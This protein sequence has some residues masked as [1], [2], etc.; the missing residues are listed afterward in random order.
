VRDPSRILLPACL[1]AAAVG[2][3]GSLAAHSGQH[4][5]GPAAP[6]GARYTIASLSPAVRARSFRFAGVA[7]LDQQA[8][9]TA[10]AAARPEA[11]RLIDLV[12]GL[13]T[14]HVGPTGPIGTTAGA[15][16]ETAAHPDGTYDVTL[17]FASV[18][19][20]MGQRGIDRL[21]LHE[22]GHL[23]D[24][25]L[26][27]D[28]LIARLDAGIPAGSGCDEGRLGGCAARE[29]RFAESFAKWATGDLGFDLYI[30]YKVPPP[31]PSLDAWGAPLAAFGR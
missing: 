8:F 28:A 17:D 19:P 12:D 16:G 15:V 4:A 29:E 10:V 21:V 13:V 31:S 22:L 23:V 25:A 18:F 6:A 27:P 14:V 26:L 24:F 3:L 2:L 1:I 30:G 20:T 5:S 9:L 7:P 11:R